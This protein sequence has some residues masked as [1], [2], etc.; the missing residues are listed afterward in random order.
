MRSTAVR[1]RSRLRRG[2]AGMSLVEVV[3]ALFV[4]T[5]VSVTAGTQFVRMLAG[6]AEQTRQQTAQAIAVEGLEAVTALDRRQVLAG[7]SHAAVTAL[8]AQLA[9]HLT[10]D[11]VQAASAG[12][13]YDP[14]ATAG[15][16]PVVPLTA[17]RTV[18]GTT[19]TV[20]TA[21]N[22]CW[23]SPAQRTCN[24]T[25]PPRDALDTTGDGVSVLRVLVRV[26]W[27]APSCNRCAA[28]TSGLLDRQD[29]P[30]FPSSTSRPV[31]ST[32]ATDEGGPATALITVGA[33]TQL[34]LTGS[35]F[36]SGATLSVGAAAGT[37][38]AVTRSDEGRRLTAQWSG[39]TGPGRYELTLSNPDSGLART[40]P[41]IVR[42]AARDD[43]LPAGPPPYP[44]QDNDM[45]RA[46]GTLTEVDGSRTT[47]PNGN[48]QARYVLAFDDLVS[49]PA[50]VTI[51]TGGAPC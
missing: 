46:G 10:D 18:G 41:L 43:C 12:D 20:R 44:V 8:N 15:S 19:Y 51:R 33:T 37:F 5:T 28:S 47:L 3:T 36:V 4:L 13:N 27:G 6:T 21:I 23:L 34:T 9:A 22:R 29:D 35:G 1:A 50:T 38:S 30:M 2:D 40:S 49:L 48:T 24:R 7:R 16:T 39:A 32:S 45:P 14:A 42:P 25:N 11:V 26:T 17:T 31:I